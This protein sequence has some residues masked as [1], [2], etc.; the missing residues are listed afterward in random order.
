[1]D[2]V[3]LPI[4]KSKHSPFGKIMVIGVIVFFLAGLIS[5]WF[6]SGRFTVSLLIVMYVMMIP[7]LFMKSYDVVG[8]IKLST[9]EIT[10][11]NPDKKE[12][13]SLS[14]IS[15]I[16]ILCIGTKGDFQRIGSIS[17]ESGTDNYISFEFQGELVSQ[18]FLLERENHPY[19]NLAFETWRA[20]GVD[21][22]AVKASG[23]EIHLLY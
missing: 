18:A 17:T 12:T 11:V 7:F 23:K 21:F 9:R 14:E 19:L 8:Y 3:F 13:F 20:E 1:M 5:I 22:K 6:A 16:K 2:L 15:K 10:I 4:T